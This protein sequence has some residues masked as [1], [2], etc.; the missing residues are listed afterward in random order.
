MSSFSTRWMLLFIF[1]VGSFQ[2]RW[3]KLASDLW[4]SFD[5]LLSVCTILETT[6]SFHLDK[7][8]LAAREKKKTKWMACPID[9]NICWLRLEKKTH[10]SNRL[11]LV[12]LSLSLSLREYLQTMEKL[13]ITIKNSNQ[14]EHR[15]AKKSK[16]Q[17]LPPPVG[18]PRSFFDHW[19]S[20]NNRKR[21]ERNG[22][23]GGRITRHIPTNKRDY[24]E[25]EL[26]EFPATVSLS[27]VASIKM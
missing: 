21:K 16:N 2:R 25:Y 14:G 15:G 5:A 1:L 8:E 9:T 6:V 4:M 20:N 7:R 18:S 24:D 11:V 27:M 3:E 19:N 22:N 23:D 12:W 26:F 17:M 13:S 10:E